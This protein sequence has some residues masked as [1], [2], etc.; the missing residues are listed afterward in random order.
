MVSSQK[1]KVLVIKSDSQAVPTY[2]VIYTAQLSYSHAFH[3]KWELWPQ[4]AYVNAPYNRN[5]R[6]EGFQTLVGVR[7]QPTGKRLSYQFSVGAEYTKENYIFQFIEHQVTGSIT[8][9]GLLI[10]AGV[11][12]PMV[13]HFQVHPFLEVIP[14]KRIMIGFSISYLMLKNESK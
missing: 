10:R 14:A 8:N 5:F 9:T 13:Q 3:E 12:W 11:D 7:H 6:L 2:A 4:V 1:W